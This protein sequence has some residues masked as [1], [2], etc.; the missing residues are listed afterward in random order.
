M[1]DHHEGCACCQWMRARQLLEGH[2][3][4]CVEQQLYFEAAV[5]DARAKELMQLERAWQL[6]AAA[7]RFVAE[8]REM[9][10]RFQREFQ[11]I[12]VKVRTYFLVSCTTL[13][14]DV[15]QS[16]PFALR[17]EELLKEAHKACKGLQG[18]KRRRRRQL[19]QRQANMPASK[20][21]I[22][23]NEDGCEG[24]GQEAAE[25]ENITVDD[26][27]EVEET[28]RDKTGPQI[29]FRNGDET[30]PQVLEQEKPE[31]LAPL[32]APP[33]GVPRHSAESLNLRHKARKLGLA[34]RYVEA[35]KLQKEA[36]RMEAEWCASKYRALETKATEGMKPSN[37]NIKAM[38]TASYNNSSLNM[39]WSEDE[40]LEAPRVPWT[41]VQIRNTGTALPGQERHALE[42]LRLEERLGHQ[43]AKLVEQ[44]LRAQQLMLQR[45]D[46]S[47]SRLAAR[48]RRAWAALGGSA[49]DMEQ[50]LRSTAGRCTSKEAPGC[51]FCSAPGLVFPAPSSVQQFNVFAPQYSIEL[52][53]TQMRTEIRELE[54]HAERRHKQHILTY[55]E[56]AA[57]GLANVEERAE[58]NHLEAMAELQAGLAT[59]EYK[60]V[61]R[62][63][64]L[65]AEMSLLQQQALEGDRVL[66]EELAEMSSKHISDALD[67]H[68]A[69]SRFAEDLRE[70]A[71]Q[72][73]EQSQQVMVEQFQ[74]H[75]SAYEARQ[76][77]KFEEKFSELKD[78]NDE[79]QERL[80]SA[81]RAL[82]KALE[83]AHPA[84]PKGQPAPAPGTPS[85]NPFAAPKAPTAP[86]F[87][88]ANAV[89]QSARNLFESMNPGGVTASPI[90]RGTPTAGPS[91]AKAPSVTAP[92]AAGLGAPTSDAL[93]TGLLETQMAI[94]SRLTDLKGE[95]KEESSKPK[96]KEAETINLPDFPNPESYRS[97]KTATREAVRAASDSPDEAFKWVLEAYDKD[98]NHTSLRDPG[99]F[100][101]LDTK[102]LAALTKVARGELS[103]EILIFKET[104][105]TKSRAVRG[106]Q[107]LYLFDQY[108]KTNEEVGSLYSVEDLLK[109]RL[110]NDD[111]STFINNWES[112]MSGL[113]H[114]PDETTLRDILFRRLRQP[115]R[116]KYDLEIYDRAREGRSP[117]PKSAD[118]AGKPAA[119][120]ISIEH[121]ADLQVA[122]KLAAAASHDEDFWEVDF[123]GNRLIRHH[124]KYRVDWYVPDNSCPVNHKKLRSQ[125]KVEQVLPIAPFVV[126]KNFNWRKVP[127]E[128]PGNMWVG[129]TI[130]YFQ[131]LPNVRFDNTVE[132]IAIEAEGKQR[133]HA[134]LPRAY[135]QTFPTAEDCPRADPKDL[136]RSILWA[137]QFSNMVEC[138]LQ[139]M[140]AKCDFECNDEEG[141][142]CEHCER[143][144]RSGCAGLVPGL[145]F[146]ADTGS[147]EDL[148][149]KSDCRAHFPDV[150]I[151]PSSRPV[152][153]ITANPVK[154]D[155]SV[156]LEVPEI[157]STLECYVLESFLIH[158]LL[159]CWCPVNL[160]LIDHP[161]H[162][163]VLEC[164][165]F[166]KL[167]PVQGRH[168]N[169]MWL[170]S[171]LLRRR[172]WGCV[173]LLFR[174]S[175]GFSL[176]P[177]IFRYQP[178]AGRE[179][180]CA[181]LH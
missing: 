120:A 95:A 91:A 124:R 74:A 161:S 71:H 51:L 83:Q 141:F 5:A 108:F 49:E 150:P 46:C 121:A 115:K 172:S 52:H 144:V 20:D 1:N 18:E 11:E 160:G 37:E 138:S 145:E 169:A 113:S 39:S 126:N 105:A 123:T 59:S 34:R 167:F 131:D 76:K 69:E 176:K 12:A 158:R 28:S 32:R 128:R 19:R 162:E 168:F 125:A 109:V 102:L 101:T 42:R 129:K 60:A 45:H 98:A 171:I 77:Q 175:G 155:R 31:L 134:Y 10:H 79:L 17:T 170:V 62:E 142:V 114:T 119:C 66:R 146:L 122:P 94:L 47:V 127:S 30:L 166:T 149:S 147:E 65:L 13:L 111:L 136:K 27:V 178:R 55:E 50:A 48:Q 133:P 75:F 14:A 3:K 63:N 85:Q 86:L 54:A 93:S 139:G 92:P 106:R 35:A 73:V 88:T 148:T 78:Q 100:L 112:V 165:K 143:L 6:E 132:M 152:S 96:V 130:F 8:R 61:N 81:E 179:T 104:E 99:K 44:S 53:I 40:L 117:R 41:F 21:G 159:G 82:E 156:R 163:G 89:P 154:G 140:K 7:G 29:A 72:H 181:T 58:K 15:E 103:R 25:E 70:Q 80:D 67:Q 110:I 16:L 4:D 135:T 2:R 180:C 90:F 23:R 22:G 43:E 24:D 56:A 84:T 157:N 68:L 177:G 151:E 164:G 26:V 64:T 36:E 173:P 137:K 174:A 38:L 57:V 9:G 97:W 116:L 153:L 87:A 118:K 33:P 107:V